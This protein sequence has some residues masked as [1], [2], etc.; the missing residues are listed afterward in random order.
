MEKEKII[1]DPKADLDKELDQKVDSDVGS[2]VKSE[3]STGATGEGLD[4]KSDKVSS[5]IDS[6][7][8][9]SGSFKSNKS[10]NGS[11]VRHKSKSRS[12]PVSVESKNESKPKEVKPNAPSSS[13]TKANRI[14]NFSNSLETEYASLGWN[15]QRTNSTSLDIINQVLSKMGINGVNL[16]SRRGELLRNFSNWKAMMLA[17]P[18][19][20]PDVYILDDPESDKS[21]SSEDLYFNV[22]KQRRPYS[23]VARGTPRVNVQILPDIISDVKLLNVSTNSTTANADAS[24][25]KYANV[26]T[27]EQDLDDSGGYQPRTVSMATRVRSNPGHVN[28]WTLPTLNKNMIGKAYHAT[29]ND[30]VLRNATIAFAAETDHVIDGPMNNSIELV[31]KGKSIVKIFEQIQDEA[32]KYASKQESGDNSWFS[33]LYLIQDPQTLAATIN[34]V[35][36]LKTFLYIMND[37][38]DGAFKSQIIKATKIGTPDSTYVGL[39]GKSTFLRMRFSQLYSTIWPKL[40]ALPMNRDVIQ[41]WNQFKVWSKLKD[42]PLANIDNS[43]LIPMFVISRA[44]GGMY[45][46]QSNSYTL[47]SV[48]NN[49]TPNNVVNADGTRSRAIRNALIF[50]AQTLDKASVSIP[51]GD[52]YAMFMQDIIARMSF[53]SLIRVGASNRMYV[54]DSEVMDTTTLNANANDVKSKVYQG[55][56]GANTGF[57]TLNKIVWAEDEEGAEAK[58]WTI[59]NYTKHADNKGLLPEMTSANIDG[60]MLISYHTMTGFMA[61]FMELMV[62]MEENGYLDDWKTLF[63]RVTPYFTRLATVAGSNSAFMFGDVINAPLTSDLPTPFSDEPSYNP[64]QNEDFFYQTGVYQPEN[65]GFSYSSLKSN[66]VSQADWALYERVPFKLLGLRRS[67]ITA[68]GKADRNVNSDNTLATIYQTDDSNKTV[69]GTTTNGRYNTY[70][71]SHSV[72]RLTNYLRMIRSLNQGLFPIY[73]GEHT[74]SQ[75]IQKLVYN[76]AS[77]YVA[78][79]ELNNRALFVNSLDEF[80]QSHLPGTF[81]LLTRATVANNAIKFWDSTN[82]DWGVDYFTVGT[83]S[84]MTNAEY[85]MLVTT[86]LVGKY[87]NLSWTNI[88]DYLNNN[89]YSRFD[90]KADELPITNFSQL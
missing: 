46:Y 14:S 89:I 8:K 1:K 75:F 12:K 84:A 7:K 29:A 70:L 67:I 6:F 4:I 28:A 11:K 62:T 45:D 22:I 48:D 17:R 47:T 78:V 61:G 49:A 82:V 86:R 69:F 10:T 71:A 74:G 73:I 27:L 37:A 51:Q 68:D 33:P 83:S 41:K 26:A 15:E 64:E 90:I 72:I 63:D 80:N 55:V 20:I 19:N 53:S 34:A 87:H 16:L 54:H 36:D 85:T 76:K 60:Q 40:K 23:T 32:A 3:M 58:P 88:I 31:N 30:N 57:S 24:Y 38:I 25:S 35:A 77:S 79:G 13:A 2:S 50:S 52:W 9:E 43:I 65:Y 56:Y 18:I 81:D 66:I 39:T 42:E 21:M 5:A 44:G 59:Q